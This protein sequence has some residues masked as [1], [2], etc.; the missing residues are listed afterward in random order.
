MTNAIS[1]KVRTMPL[2]RLSFKN[3]PMSIAL[4][5]SLASA[6]SLARKAYPTPEAASDAFV[7]AIARSD[8]S[9]LRTVLGPD[10]K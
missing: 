4:V 3:L 2:D 6:S 7:D 8:A 5:L 10:W 1:L 9:A